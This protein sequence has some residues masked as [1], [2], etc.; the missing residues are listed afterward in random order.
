MGF[1]DSALRTI[2]G[3]A[4]GFAMGGPLG[5]AAGGL[6]GLLSGGG[7]TGSQTSTVQP[8][9]YTEQERAAMEAAY[10][11]IQQNMN[12]MN[13]EEREAYI[14]NLAGT[15]YAPMAQ[16][17]DVQFRRLEGSTRMAYARGG[18]L[19]GSAA[20]ASRRQLIGESARA[21]GAASAQA[22]QLGEQSYF[23]QERVRQGD[24]SGA[25]RT[26]GLIESNRLGGATRT[27]STQYPDTFPS[28][29][30]AGL[31]YAM[32]SPASYFNTQMMVPDWMKDKKPQPGVVPGGFYRG[33][34]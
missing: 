14:S 11:A 34:G 32:N 20:D 16:E 15:Y 29:M 12:G 31:G 28:D 25:Q 23:N 30:M 1:F 17:I 6:G 33:N 19:G 9:Q 2:G 8:R 3:A 24:L 13:P 22:R 21:K 5:A 7:H 18:G 10:A 27:S 4:T 26:V